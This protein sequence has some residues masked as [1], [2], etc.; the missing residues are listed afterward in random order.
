MKTEIGYFLSILGLFLFTSAGNA[1]APEKMSYQAVIRDAS[2]ALVVNQT[3]GMQISILQGTVD[4]SAVYIE[5]QSASTNA[6][7]LVSIEIGAGS[8]S[9]GSF[10]TIDWSNGPYFVKSETDPA[11][12][13]N[14]TIS[15]TSQ[16][17]S[18]PYALYAKTSGSS[19]PGPAGTDG[20]T[21]LNGTIDPASWD[22]VDGDFYI[23][24]ATN[25]IF[26]PKMGFWGPGTSLVGPQ[27]EQGIQGIQGIQGD[28]GPSVMNI[29]N[30]SLAFSTT[31][32]SNVRNA[33]ILA[34]EYLTIP[35]DGFYMLSYI[36]EGNNSSVVTGVGVT[37]DLRGFTGLVK[38]S[39]PNYFLNGM[40]V[41]TFV[42][43]H[44]AH[45]DFYNVYDNAPAS[46]SL[47][48]IVYLSAG[49]Q[50]TVGTT[51]SA[52]APEPTANWVVYPT[53]IEAIKLRD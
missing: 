1:Q 37:Y 8:I 21:V 42:P 30:T 47:Q 31:V 16:L 24:T 33:M 7:G 4:G 39:N 15:G 51:V 10:E 17:L 49:D 32:S 38:T 18:V 50:I 13:T 43:Y 53:R 11:G 14:Y 19:I 45:P 44:Y 26:G 46:H 41:H 29:Q 9:F 12:G 5:T 3:V 20:K 35:E 22:G 23:N 34:T 2:N 25:Q 48:V 40:S 36:G 27:G 6:N 28:P 52:S